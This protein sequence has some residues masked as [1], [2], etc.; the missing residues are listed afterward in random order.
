MQAYFPPGDSEFMKELR[1]GALV[2]SLIIMCLCAAVGL[3]QSRPTLE[4]NSRRLERLEDLKIE[5]RMTRME[6]I[7]EDAQRNS[8]RT[9]TMLL[10]L[11]V[12]VGILGLEG[13]ARLLLG[14]KVK[15]PRV[16]LE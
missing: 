9:F 11:C 7:Q 16:K 15:D 12:P 2:G 5:Q 14:W 6:T 1:V 13:I 8:D 4:E 10:G 3:S